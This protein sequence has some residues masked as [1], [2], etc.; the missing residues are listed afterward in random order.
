MAQSHIHHALCLPHHNLLPSLHVAVPPPLSPELP[1]RRT[2][3]RHR[4]AASGNTVRK[5]VITFSFRLRMEN[6]LKRT[7]PTN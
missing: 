1:V 7:R 6:T 4:E 3:S 2:P 5:Q